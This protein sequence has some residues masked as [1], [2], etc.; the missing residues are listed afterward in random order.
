MKKLIKMMSYAS[1][2]IEK[3]NLISKFE[4]LRDE[5]CGFN[6]RKI[7]IPKLIKMKD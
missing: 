2:S 6:N 7:K 4:K 1:V 5:N 3:L